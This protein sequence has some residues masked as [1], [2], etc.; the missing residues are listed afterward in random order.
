MLD[1][2][3]TTYQDVHSIIP[4]P[5]FKLNPQWRPLVAKRLET[6]AAVTIFCEGRPIAILGMNPIH[7]G[8]FQ[9]WAIIS[10]EVQKHPVSFHK[11]A[12]T[13]FE[14]WKTQSGAHR[15]QMTVQAD[16]EAA[17]RWA[18]ALGFNYEGKL[19]SYGEDG[20]DFYI[21]GWVK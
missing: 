9:A 20:S 4:R 8:V 11:L 7:R 6:Q 13:I 10:S 15:V 16:F 14:R 1:A 17:R 19:R 3:A 5:E 2:L 18:L 12:L 21:Y